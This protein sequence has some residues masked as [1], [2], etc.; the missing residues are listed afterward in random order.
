MHYSEWPLPCQ[1]HVKSSIKCLLKSILNFPQLP[2]GCV[3]GSHETSYRFPAQLCVKLPLQFLFFHVWN[4]LVMCQA[5]NHVPSTSC[6]SSWV[7][8]SRMDPAW[9]RRLQY[10]DLC[11]LLSCNLPHTHRNPSHIHKQQNNKTSY[12]MGTNYFNASHPK[13]KG[14]WQIIWFLVR[15]HIF[16]F[17]Y[18]HF[19]VLSPRYVIKITLESFFISRSQWEKKNIAAIDCWQ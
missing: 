1:I 9:P 8:N 3:S 12:F 19:P 10:I 13:Q 5:G 16:F 6:T 18:F 11:S 14:I 7:I 15:N 2:L 17:F 4:I